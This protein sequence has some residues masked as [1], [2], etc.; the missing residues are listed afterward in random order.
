MPLLLAAR[1]PSIMKTRNFHSATRLVHAGKHESEHLGKAVNPPVVRAS[2]V[3][4]DSMQ[5]WQ[6]VRQRRGSERLFSYG[7]RGTPT[8]FAL[9]DMITELE[10]GYRSRLYPTGLAAIA[11]VFLSYLRPGDHVLICDSTYLPVRALGT[12]FLSNYGISYSFFCAQQLDLADL[13]QSNTR[14]IY[15][16]TPGSL[17][18]EM[19]DLPAIAKFTQQ[20][21]LLLVADNTWGSGLL[22]QPLALGADISIMAATKYLGGH[23]D[24]VMGT[25]CAQKQH[26]EPLQRMSEAFGMTVSPDDAWL[27]LRGIRS[28]QARLRMHAQ[29]ADLVLQ[30]LSAQPQVSH[31]FSPVLA[32]DP[33]HILWQRDCHGA[34][35]LLSFALAKSSKQQVEAMLDALQLFGLGASWGGYESLASIADLSQARSRGDWSAHGVVV[36]L[37]IGLE[38]PRDLIADLEQAFAHL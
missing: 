9:E 18:Y 28:L 33:G 16:E 4:F 10:G 26:W 5:D 34:N 37:H 7:A 13:V 38:D 22:Y 29:H 19:L 8:T 17:V 3:V 31:V 11:M 2:T 6:D 25:V 27:V 24:V 30:W 14:M 20:H 36:R 12:E 23:S 21:N 35:G 15:V 1:G 32:D